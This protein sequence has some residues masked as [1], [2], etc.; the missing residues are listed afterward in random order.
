M[1][2]VYSHVVLGN[3]LNLEHNQAAE[4]LKTLTTRAKLQSYCWQREIQTVVVF[5]FDS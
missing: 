5:S 3:R 4:S 2:K 1:P